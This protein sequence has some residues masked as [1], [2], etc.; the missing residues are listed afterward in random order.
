MKRVSVL[1]AAVAL[2]VV[3]LVA[4]APR[5]FTQ[6][7]P[8]PGA[9][10]DAAAI[11]H[12]C[13]WIKI[14][15]GDIDDKIASW[16]RQIR[17]INKYSDLT[18]PNIQNALKDIDNKIADLK[19]KKADL[20][21][22]LAECQKRCAEAKA[23]QQPPP[24]PV[25]P[26][27]L[28]G[29]TGGGGGG[30]GGGGTDNGGGTGSDTGGSSGGSTEPPHHIC[31]PNAPSGQFSPA[32]PQGEGGGGKSLLPPPLP[33]APKD[34]GH[35]ENWNHMLDHMD[36]AEDWGDPEDVWDVAD[37]IDD[38]IADAYDELAANPGDADA[39]A[40]LDW[41]KGA[42][43]YYARWKASIRNMFRH[44]IWGPFKC[45]PIEI[46][47]SRQKPSSFLDHFSIGIGVGVGGGGH[48]DDRG[49]RDNNR[50]NQQQ[51]DKPRD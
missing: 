50:D 22:Q 49:R 12:Q 10:P 29:P 46:E 14:Q 1:G 19:A 36:D 45:P 13:E 35:R 5:A 51:W 38:A 32:S 2:V 3:L 26:G 43:D 28:H 30:T 40:R 27:P 9:K 15:I 24:A 11:C 44:S 42:R 17:S 21:A 18:D 41:L 48:E 33:P 37:D 7:T 20:E 31:P 47:P 8:Q 4:F 23:A 25:S 6:D 16:Q 34:K 39:Q